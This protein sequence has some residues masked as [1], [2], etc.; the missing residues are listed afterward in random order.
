MWYKPALRGAKLGD[1]DK[2]K[3]GCIANTKTKSRKIENKKCI[4]VNECLRAC[5]FTLQGIAGQ[6]SLASASGGAGFTVGDG[7]TRK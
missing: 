5:A 7:R 2:Y 4:Y 3:F 1:S 6:A